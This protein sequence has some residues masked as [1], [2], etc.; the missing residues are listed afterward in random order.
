[1]TAFSRMLA[2]LLP[3]VFACLFLATALSS[4]NAQYS[5]GNPF[6]K[7]RNDWLSKVQS[8]KYRFQRQD[9]EGVRNLEA[10][11]DQRDHTLLVEF[12][13][14]GV[15]V[16]RVLANPHYVA[17]L[18]KPN[19]ADGAWTLEEIRHERSQSRGDGRWTLNRGIDPYFVATT[20]FFLNRADEVKQLNQT[21]SRDDHFIWTP[22][23][24]SSEL[25]DWSES[26]QKITEIVATVVDGDV[27]RVSLATETNLNQTVYSKTTTVEFDNWQVIDGTRMPLSAK[28]YLDSNPEPYVEFQV[29]AV[30][31]IVLNSPFDISTCYLRHYNLPEPSETN[32]EASWFGGWSVALILLGVSLIIF[33]LILLLIRKKERN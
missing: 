11:G 7:Y 30:S 27:S 8:Y 5:D 19:T 9:G 12:D 25:E 33:P 24:S 31:D 13:T 26:R 22:D 14:S 16:R 20:M 32:S 2:T 1:M 10:S 23:S 15:E 3:A 21:S 6:D 17:V 29:N 4:S 18:S 28:Y